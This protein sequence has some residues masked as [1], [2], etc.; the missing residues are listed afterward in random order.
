[1]QNN[2]STLDFRRTR[3]LNESLTNDFDVLN[4]WA[5]IGMFCQ[6]GVSQQVVL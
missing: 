4:N 1:M 6:N 2:M 3:R 5:L